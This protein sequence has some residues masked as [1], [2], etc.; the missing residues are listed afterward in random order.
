MEDN[1]ADVVVWKVS[2]HKA[3]ALQRKIETPD[4]DCLAFALRCEFGWTTKY[5]ENVARLVFERRS[6]SNA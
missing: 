5:S 3:E 1:T 6:V 2:I 4:A